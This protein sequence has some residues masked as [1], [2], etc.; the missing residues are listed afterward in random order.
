MENLIL[1][2]VTLI[3]TWIMGYFAK[4]SKYISNNLIPVQNLIIGIIV[5]IIYW[6]IS[7]DFEAALMLTGSLAGGLYDIVHNLQKLVETKEEEQDTFNEDDLESID[8]EAEDIIG[9]IEEE[10]IEILADENEE[11]EENEEFWEDNIPEA[12]ITEGEE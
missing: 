8:T 9:E 5:T 2:A 7:K 1:Y 11:D 4:K 10:E 12:E 3:V 6:I